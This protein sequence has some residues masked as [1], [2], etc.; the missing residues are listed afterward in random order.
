MYEID[1]DNKSFY[2][3]REPEL[4]QITKDRLTQLKNLN[5]QLVG[6]GEFGIKG[7]FSGLYIERV[8]NYSDKS[9]KEYID[10]IEEVK[11]KNKL[12]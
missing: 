2:N 4:E 8:W 5:V 9:W 7:V 12:K 3:G 10:F 11:A 1:I 6:Y